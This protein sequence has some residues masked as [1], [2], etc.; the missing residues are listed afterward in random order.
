MFV[1]R[2]DT[3]DPTGHWTA[4]HY[5]GAAGLFASFPTLGVD[6]NG[7]YVG[8]ANF[9][10]SIFGVTASGV[11]LTAIPKASLLAATPTLAGATT[12]T[13]PDASVTMGWSPQVVTN[14]DPNPTH[15]TVVATGYYGTEF[16]QIVVTNA[17]LVGR[18]G[19]A[20]G[21]STAIATNLRTSLP[22]SSRQPGSRILSGPTT[23]GT[24]G[25]STRSAT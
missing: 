21:T 16:D 7:V 6:A 18:G 20:L 11:T 10:A 5:A 2:S 25:P 17:H 8:T 12:F 19:R 3:G 1:A 13:Q 14:F 23:T 22:G 15:A 24:P 4:V 9:N